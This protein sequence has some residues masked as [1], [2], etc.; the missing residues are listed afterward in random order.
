MYQGLSAPLAISR[1]EKAKHDTLPHFD[2]GAKYHVPANVP[3]IRYFVSFIVQFMFHQTLC[4]TA[5]Y[6][7]NLFECDIYNSIEAGDLLKENL[8][9]GFSEPWPIILESLGGSQNMS[10]DA[11]VEYFSPLM[12]YINE[13]LEA[14]GHTPGWSSVKN[15]NREA[16]LIME[17]LDHILKEPLE[18]SVLMS[19]NYNTN[20]TDEN[21]EA[22]VNAVITL[23]KYL[24]IKLFR[25]RLLLML[26]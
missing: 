22:Q 12:E 8:K 13:A 18:N 26:V 24:P 2:A 17:N 9:K 7:G 15:T 11:I 10:A 25:M 6:T 21:L 4:E 5:G 14:N 19:W 1:K 16:I 20:I 23:F 3:Y